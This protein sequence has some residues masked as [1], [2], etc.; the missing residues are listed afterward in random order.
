MKNS[1]KMTSVALACMLATSALA[2]EDN[3]SEDQAKN[4]N[5]AD[6]LR[7]SWGL[8]W[9]PTDLWNG[10]GEEL[11]IDLFLAQIS[12]LKTID[13]VQVHLNESYINSPSHLGPHELLESFWQGDTSPLGEPINL[14][15]PRAS[16]GVDPFLEMIKKIQKD[17]MKV[18]VYLNSS[19]L[20]ERSATLANPDYMPNI[21]E[22][23]KKWVDTNP[24]AQAFIASQPYHTGIWDAD[25]QSYVDASET[26]P[27]RK[28]MFAYAEFIL[29][30]YAVRYGELIDGWLFDSGSFMYSN[31]DS[32]TNGV[33]ED[34]QIYKA[35]ADACHAGN[36]M[37]AISFNN[38]P[39]RITEALNPFSEATHYDDYMFGHPYNG[40]RYIGNH[41]NTN[42]ERNYRHI[43]K[44]TETNGNIH[45]GSL[46]AGTDSQNWDWD[47]K[48]VGHFDPPMSR[49]RWNSGGDPGLTD[50]EFVQWNYESAVGGGAISWGAPL[51]A[52]PQSGE[53]LTIREWGMRQL[54]L[55]DADLAQR[56]E[57]GAPN[58]ARAHTILN[59]AILDE[60][61]R[62]VLVDGKDFW[63]PE[64][65][66]DVTL[67]LLPAGA[68]SWLQLVKD[69]EI[70]GQWVLY[71]QPNETQETFYEF[72]MQAT[73]SD[74]TTDRVIKLRVGEFIPDPVLVEPEAPPTPPF[75]KIFAE[76][77]HSYPDGVA[78][79][80]SVTI[81]APDSGATFEIAFN[82]TPQVG[83]SIHS[84]ASGGGA[85]ESAWGVS[86][87]NIFKGSDGELAQLSNIGV[88]NFQANGSCLT[89]ENIVD[90]EFF[91]AEIVNAQSRN[92]RVLVTSNGVENAVGGLKLAANVAQHRLNYDSALVTEVSF[93]VGNE[94]AT[95]KWSVNHVEV[96][97][98][99]DNAFL[100]KG[101]YDCDG[102]LGRSDLAMF[103]GAI[104]STKGDDNYI[105]GADLDNDGVVTLYDFVQW[106][107]LYRNQQAAN[108]SHF[109]R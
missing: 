107:M 47:D 19:N 18:Q 109:S 21:T 56:Q 92:D 101:D 99:I 20:L 22:R 85:T 83:T 96:A 62:Y 29:K 84:G 23:W 12:H 104:G 93:G 14:V 27:E 40:G 25:T 54:D 64:G 48:V 108:S 17:G 66:Q 24:E 50:E 34:Q 38:S 79:M 45:S 15:V 97:Y 86:D 26:Y 65:T 39:N 67:T 10:A 63:D 7:G 13:Y 46:D 77:S 41:D 57:T 58:W 73:D 16:R 9:K 6:W 49:T 103:W 43:Q 80:T 11:T 94:S 90:L 87:D 59:D 35:F 3:H 36:P 106:Y 81:T 42:Y 69:E 78:T 82:V 28:Y 100:V 74:G 37:A 2:V 72:V 91:N 31:G 105:A 88:T 60:A 52:P 95:N 61:Y 53:Q 5:R 4:T 44:V 71:G 8:N 76:A 30:E 98:Q 70:A 32:P 1:I 89:A 68:P 33:K 102:L 75:V 55:M 51:F